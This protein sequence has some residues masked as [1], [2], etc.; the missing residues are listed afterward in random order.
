V[1]TLPED[2]NARRSQLKGMK[3]TL[4]AI[5]N[6]QQVEKETSAGRMR[7]P[8]FEKTLLEIG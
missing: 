8:I 5:F 7:P 2:R 4:S 1:N 3:D 6:F